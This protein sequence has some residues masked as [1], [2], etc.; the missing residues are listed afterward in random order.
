MPK[1]FKQNKFA[2]AFANILLIAIWIPISSL[3]YDLITYQ[4]A[5]FYLYK[6]GDLIKIIPP[7]WV[8]YY[9]W[10]KRKGFK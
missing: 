9:L 5:P 2:L 10:I 4:D 8:T 3:I 6:L 7:I 1:I